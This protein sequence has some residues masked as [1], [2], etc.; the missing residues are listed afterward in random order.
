M[1]PK[2]HRRRADEKPRLSPL[3]IGGIPMLPTPHHTH[4]H[5]IMTETQ[6]QYLCERGQ[7]EL[8]ETLYLDA[9]QTLAQAEQ[10]AWESNSFDTLAR[11]YLPLQE[12]RRQIR[13]RCGEGA[14]RLHLY[15]ATP[16]EVIDPQ[17]ILRDT[18]HGQ[19]LV[20]G[21]NSMQPAIEVRR[22]AREQHLYVETFLATV[23]SEVGGNPCI[24]IQPTAEGLSTN[25]VLLKPDEIPADADKGTAQTFATV[26]DLWERLH[27]PFLIAARNEPDPLRRMQAYRMTIRVDPACELAHQFLAEIARD[28][29]RKR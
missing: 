23:D 2:Q 9:A 4:Y 20:A 8:M 16:A 29:A 12:A 11:L 28:L 7:L 6:L 22:L 14:V 25:C 19:L 21:W 26:M 17:Q 18:P 10:H 15:P 1:R 5:P 24:Q 3:F 13:Q 27:T